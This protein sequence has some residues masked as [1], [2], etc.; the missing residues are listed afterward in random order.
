[1]RPIFVVFTC[2]LTIAGASGQNIEY[3]KNGVLKRTTIITSIQRNQIIIAADSKQ[4]WSGDLLHDNSNVPLKCKIRHIDNF[5]FAAEGHTT[6]ISPYIDFLEIIESL[7]LSKKSFIDKVDYIESNLQD[8]VKQFVI[9][10]Q[11]HNPNSFNQILNKTLFSVLFSAFEND[12]PV[13]MAIYWDIKSTDIGGWQIISQR[14]SSDLIPRH[15]IQGQK[16]GID[17]LFDKNPSIKNSLYN[18]SGLIELIDTQIQD[19]P[20][21]V[22]GP[23]DV[24]VITSH[25]HRWAQ[26]KE[27]CK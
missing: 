10:F 24:V 25:G 19:T 14:A 20:D 6:M 16:T 2:Y 7:D 21:K 4:A 17:K 11:R 26:K 22:G 8:H 15:M 9:T 13:G 3:M 27:Q 12:L 18:V 5:F 1:M 23:I